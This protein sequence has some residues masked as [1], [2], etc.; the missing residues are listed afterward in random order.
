MVLSVESDNEELINFIKTKLNY[1]K[2]TATPE[3][4]LD[5]YIVPVRVKQN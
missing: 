2:V 1:K 5:S 4:N 3:A